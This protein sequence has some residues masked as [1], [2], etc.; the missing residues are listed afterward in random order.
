MKAI[1][2][3]IIILLGLAA[4]A[5]GNDEATAQYDSETCEALAVKVERREAISQEEYC[6][7]IG[8][9]EAI[10]RYLIEKSREIAEEPSENRNDS[11]RTLLADPEYMERFSRS[12]EHT[13]ELQSRI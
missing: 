2:L 1:Y 11:W 6:E 12:E 13:S 8:Q 4:Y 9:N 5:C 3:F 10:L 7:M